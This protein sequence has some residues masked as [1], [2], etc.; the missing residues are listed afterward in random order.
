VPDT[1]PV[2]KIKK[3]FLTQARFESSQRQRIT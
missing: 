2:N 1:K 3:K